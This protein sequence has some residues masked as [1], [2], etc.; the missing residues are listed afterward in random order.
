[1][2]SF[3]EKNMGDGAPINAGFMVLEPRIFDY[4]EGDD[5]VFERGPLKELAEQGELMSYMHRGFWQCM[6]TKREKD[7][8]ESLWEKEGLLG[9]CGITD[10]YERCAGFL[11]G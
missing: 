7:I 5:T 4:I 11:Q 6:D 1:M 8:L 10:E 2:H 3:R 9:K